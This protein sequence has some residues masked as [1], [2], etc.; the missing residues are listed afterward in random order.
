MLRWLLMSKLRTASISLSN[1][2]IR[3]ATLLL[4][5]NTSKISPRKQNCPIASTCAVRS[6]P[7]ATKVAII[8]CCSRS[9]PKVIT[10]FLLK[11]RGTNCF[12]CKASAVMKTIPRSSPCKKRNAAARPACTSKLWV[13][14]CTRGK[15]TG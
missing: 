4:M 6:Y 13:S 12:C 5:G 10:R 9:S 2:S 14:A 8:S 3:T 1:H 7:K 15:F 11:L